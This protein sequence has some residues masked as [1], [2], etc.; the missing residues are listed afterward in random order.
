MADIVWSVRSRVLKERTDRTRR[1]DISLSI[2]MSVC[3][4]SGPDPHLV[5]RHIR[6]SGS[7]MRS[8]QFGLGVTVR[9]GVRLGHERIP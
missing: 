9:D 2:E 5:R 6:K 3:P 7:L 4:V 8:P 1:T